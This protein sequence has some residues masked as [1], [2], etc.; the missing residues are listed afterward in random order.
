MAISQ[1]HAI[2]ESYY[3]QPDLFNIQRLMC[4]HCGLIF[5][6][7]FPLDDEP[8]GWTRL[9]NQRIYSS[10]VYEDFGLIHDV[11]QETPIEEITEHC[12]RCG[13]E[14]KED[15][16]ILINVSQ[17]VTF[18]DIRKII[19]K[20]ESE[21]LELKAGLREV[22]KSKVKAE[23][24]KKIAKIVASFA[25]KRGGMLIIGVDDKTKEIKG[26][27]NLITPKEREDFSRD[28]KDMISQIEPAPP[29]YH[30]NFIE[31][32]DKIIAIITINI[33]KHICRV[34]NKV[35]RRDG[36]S[37]NFLI[38]QESVDNLQESRNLNNHTPE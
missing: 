2:D 1:I 28:I 33:S 19:E 15:T 8:L 18:D 17:L 10:T 31:D 20:G 26:I 34:D 22:S 3:K 23:M 16:L 9:S 13:L 36:E 30:L 6:F 11:I 29:N 35:P 38:N 37:S 7:Q 4:P 12:S 14:I 21:T 27:E 24:K 25:N 32:E 5:D